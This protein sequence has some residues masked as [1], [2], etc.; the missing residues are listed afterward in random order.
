MKLRHIFIATSL[1][2]LPVVAQETYE[3]ARIMGE[4]LN[5]TARYVGM[6]G[7]LEALGADISTIGTNPAGIGLFRHSTFSISAG[8]VFKKSGKEFNSGSKTNLSFDQI[9]LVYSTRTGANEYINFGFNY[10]KGKNFNYF[11]NAA[12]SLNGS[13]QN[14][15]SYL[16]G[17]LG[18]EL[19]GGFNIGQ[20]KKGEYNGYV[21]DKSEQTALTWSQ[22]DYL[23]WNTM[24]PDAK[25]GNKFF[26]YDASS[27]DFNRE[28]TGYVGNYDFNSSA[29]FEDRVFLGFTLGIKDVHYNSYSEYREQLSGNS[30]S[31]TVQDQRQIVGVGYDVSFGAIVRPVLSSPFRIGAYIK[32]PTWYELET[33]NQTVIHNNATS[34]GTYDHGQV[35]NSYKFKL[36]TPWRFGL[37]LGHTIGNKFAIGVTYEY[38]DYSST[39]TRVNDGTY[40]DYYYGDIYETSVKDAVMNNH[41]KGALKGVSTFKVGAE[42]KPVADLSLRVGYNYVG[43]KYSANAQKNPSLASLGTSYSS[44]TDFTNWDAIN[45]FTCGIGYRINDFS[46]DMAYQYSAQNGTF[47]PFSS[48]TVEDTKNNKVYKNTPTPTKVENNRGQLLFTLG[49]HF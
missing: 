49:F 35:S 5:G 3:N 44:A 27:Y 28:N 31:V 20:N 8:P 22:L 17:L 32:S 9:G 4:D 42:F 46:I 33:S 24:I 40:V 23:Y 1:V 48:M 39:N 47:Y 26:Y 34:G 12:N 43:S 15:Q 25:N 21:N 45:R 7:A 14:A 30:G 18:S 36:W 16:K 10:H 37:S 13:S 6:G 11:L 41:T 38:E 29:N 2:A 19:D